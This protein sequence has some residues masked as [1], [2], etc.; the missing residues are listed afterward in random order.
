MRTMLAVSLAVLILAGCAHGGS[1][2]HHAPVIDVEPRYT[3]ERIPVEREVCRDH[4]GYERTRPDSK[5]PTVL[6]AIIGGVIGNQFGSGNGRRAAT[7]AGAVL[8]GSIAH[9]ASQRDA[10]YER[11]T[12][13]RCTVV[14]D[15]HERE[16][17]ADYLVTYQYGGELYH[18]VTRDH[19]GDYIRVRVEVSPAH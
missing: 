5:T 4:T 6:G 3:V 15:W 7:A 2:Y 17:V 16:V 14:R 1:A 12:R 10:R 19:P 18:T 11:V 13:Q 8:G 9:D